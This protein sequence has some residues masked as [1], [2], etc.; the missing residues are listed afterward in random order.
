V[1]V[2]YNCHENQEGHSDEVSH[3]G[4]EFKDIEVDV[5]SDSHGG[6][7]VLCGGDQTH[8]EEQDKGQS[9]GEATLHVD[10]RL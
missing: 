2:S 3:V 5:L 7:W 9:K 6:V 10:F 1:C 8:E 4:R